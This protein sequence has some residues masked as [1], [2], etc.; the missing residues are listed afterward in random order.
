MFFW[1]DDLEGWK[2]GGGGEKDISIAIIDSGIDLAHENK[3]VNIRDGITVIEGQEDRVPFDTCWRQEDYNAG[4]C[5]AHGVRLAGIIA[6]GTNN[7][8][9]ISGYA[10]NVTII[11]IKDHESGE[12]RREEDSIE[13]FKYAVGEKTRTGKQISKKADV[14]LFAAG[15]GKCP[16]PEDV[17]SGDSDLAFTIADAIEKNIPVVLPVG[18]QG[19]DCPRSYWDEVA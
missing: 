7:N 11:P 9:G 8:R 6:A 18:N 16:E 15:P 5:F 14:I 4:K 3:P 13:A 19:K 17:L 2:K 12:I 10:Y 1:P